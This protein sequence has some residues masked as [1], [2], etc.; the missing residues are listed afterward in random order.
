MGS[1]LS[2]PVPQQ[3]I[4]AAPKWHHLHK[5]GVLHGD[6]YGPVLP[7]VR[8]FTEVR[9]AA[10]LAVRRVRTGAGAVR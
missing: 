4:P 1:I 3:I 2:V 6:W 9:G 5:R 10:H 7:N 8:R